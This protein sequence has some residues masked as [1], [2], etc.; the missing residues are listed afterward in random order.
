MIIR[1]QLELQEY[2]LVVRKQ[3]LELQLMETFQNI[4]DYVV[5]E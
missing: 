2:V 3:I 1:R 5:Q 4:V